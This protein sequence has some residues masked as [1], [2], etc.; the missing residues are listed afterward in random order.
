MSTLINRGGKRGAPSY[1]NK[2]LKPS[3]RIPTTARLN[4]P[5]TNASQKR[6]RNNRMSRSSTKASWT[7]VISKSNRELLE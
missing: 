6:Y 5:P 4:P 1:T 3:K 7:S 2:V